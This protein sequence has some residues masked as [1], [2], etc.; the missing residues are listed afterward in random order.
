[1]CGHSV[2]SVA[3]LIGII[4]LQTALFVTVLVILRNPSDY[5]NYCMF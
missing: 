2:I 5:I 4:I 1:M 3:D